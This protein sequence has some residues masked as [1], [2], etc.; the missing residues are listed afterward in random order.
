VRLHEMLEMLKQE[1]LSLRTTGAFVKES[2]ELLLLMMFHARCSGLTD[3]R[4]GGDSCSSEK[5]SLHRWKVCCDPGVRT[6][7]G[8]C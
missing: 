8:C 5:S 3:A 2:L 6:L 1:A 7:Y 4:S